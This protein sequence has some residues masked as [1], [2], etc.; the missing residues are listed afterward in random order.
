MSRWAISEFGKVLK[1]NSFCAMTDAVPIFLTIL[2]PYPPRPTG[3]GSLWARK[4]LGGPRMHLP[5][6]QA[7]RGV[8]IC[9]RALTWERKNASQFFHR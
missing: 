9:P 8:D 3:V 2:P 5:Q 4:T 7:H 1:L 6:G